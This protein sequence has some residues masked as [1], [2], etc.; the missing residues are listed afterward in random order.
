M[1][2]FHYFI[3]NEPLKIVEIFSITTKK[4][5]TAFTNAAHQTNFPNSISKKQNLGGLHNVDVLPGFNIYV[6][7]SV[8]PPPQTREFSPHR[9]HTD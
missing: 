3:S 5:N 6:C 1:Y 8:I 2:S 4:G 9:Q 7:L